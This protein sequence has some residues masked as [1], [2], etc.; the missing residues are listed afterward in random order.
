MSN[1]EAY[2]ER[3]YQNI[4]NQK[5]KYE[6]FLAFSRTLNNLFVK[7]YL[8]YPEFSSLDDAKKM[9]TKLEFSL[10]NEDAVIYFSIKDDVEAEA[11]QSFKQIKAEH[12]DRYID[13][14]NI[15]FHDMQA[16]FNDEIKFKDA[17]S[18]HVVDKYFFSDIE[19][20]T[21]RTLYFHSLDIE[22]KKLHQDISKNNFKEFQKSVINKKS[23]FC[24][25]SG[26]SFDT[27][28]EI[29]FPKNVVNVICNSIVKNSDFLSHIDSVDVI[30]FAD[31]VFHFGPS[32]Y[33]KR[34]RKDVLEVVQK[35][36]SFV[37]VL[38]VNFALMLKHYPELKDNLIAL[39]M[40]DV[41][42][43]PSSE[44]MFVKQSSNILTLLML[45]IASSVAEYIFVMGADGREPNENY[46]WKHSSSAQY[47]DLMENAFKT[48]PS[49]FRDRDYEDYYDE[50]C[51]VVEQLINYGEQSAKSYASITNSFIPAFQK[52]YVDFSQEF[53]QICY[54][55]EQQKETKISQNNYEFAIQMNK[56]YSYID[57][58]YESELRIALYGYGHIGR[59]LH[60]ALQDRVS[61]IFDKN[62]QIEGV[63][64][65]QEIDRYDFDI[66]VITV[67]GREDEIKKSLTKY[68]EKIYA[69]DLSKQA[70][71]IQIIQKCDFKTL[72]GP[73]TRSSHVNIDETKLVSMMLSE[74]KDGVMVDVGAHSG[75]SLKEFLEKGWSVYA[76]E[77][78]PNNFTIVKQLASKYENLKLFNLAVSDRAGEKVD[79]F[80]SSES[81]GVSSLIPFT[82]K[83]EKVCRVSTT[84]LTDEIIQ[85]GIKKVD[86]LKVD[87]EGYDLIVLKSYP[88]D[89]GFLPEVIECEFED[90]KT[91]HLGYNVHDMISF[92]Q[93]KGY[94]VYV[95]QWHPIIRYG[96]SHDHK[97]IFKYTN[98]IIE[99]DSW[100]NLIAFQSS[101]NEDEIRKYLDQIINQYSKIIYS[102]LYT[103]A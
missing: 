96:I 35:Y 103:M 3:D 32:E 55:L 86:F 90:N 16:F 70:E 64:K 39:S 76:Y 63:V 37:F 82:A 73:Y 38:E 31:P 66:L 48:H 34:F 42:I 47:D 71:P 99:P 30:T 50:H 8:L 6:T 59:I 24:F 10:P 69:I 45:P 19:A 7:E 9:M 72:C 23:A 81:S 28:K 92:L 68:A 33:A 12:L 60:T 20:E 44:K 94:V 15:L 18:L 102:N 13:E 22:Q 67:L 40:K 43:F 98:Q 83:H 1:H 85:Y 25:N 26:P 29:T 78:D 95:S 79:F 11:K 101:P 54:Q 61:V 51:E 57:V 93:D 36:N 100:G 17:N 62:I 91:K 75:T 65:P 58:L 2:K 14:K 88:W 5:N 74:K 80:S 21:L 56:L 87:T 52:R 77:P 53:D 49:F 97:M 84:T 41:F 27:Y 89:C 46:F 4:E